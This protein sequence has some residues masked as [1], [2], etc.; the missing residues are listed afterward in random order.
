MIK[1]ILIN[2]LGT[3][4]LG[5]IIGITYIYITSSK[6]IRK[7]N[8]LFYKNLLTKYKSKEEIQDSL[9][10]KICLKEYK[11]VL[12]VLDKELK[13][14]GYTDI[15]I[16]KYHPRLILY[17]VPLHK[18]IYPF[19]GTFFSKNFSYNKITNEI[20]ST[21]KLSEKVYDP[22]KGVIVLGLPKLDINSLTNEEKKELGKIIYNMLLH[23]LSHFT[24]LKIS[25]IYNYNNILF[26]SEYTPILMQYKFGK[27]LN[28]NNPLYRL[29]DNKELSYE[30]DYEEM[31]KEIKGIKKETFI[32]KMNMLK[33]RLDKD[34]YHTL[35]YF[36]DKDRILAKLLPTEY[37][38]AY[39]AKK[40]LFSSK[41]N[42]QFFEKEP[43]KYIVV[44]LL[45]RKKIILKNLDKDTFQE[46][47]KK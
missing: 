29:I 8:N 24:F 36:V 40:D 18:G 14:E 26:L 11:N 12:A 46:Y 9:Y 30:A 42:I 17:Y 37:L 20:L 15:N 1:K 2:I 27:K 28:F 19:W 13:K 45:K 23:E 33:I 6:E 38:N 44:S 32:N 7:D 41:K 43:I 4:L 31:K 47:F 16:K 35:Y 39:L 34:Y 22:L 10:R 21:L 25:K 3:V 5:L